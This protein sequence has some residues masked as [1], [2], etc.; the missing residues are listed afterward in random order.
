MSQFEGTGSFEASAAISAFR[1]VTLDTSR[2]V[3]AS[4]TAV[5]PL[6]ITQLDADSG[7][8]VAVKFYP[9]SPGTF[10]VSVT[11]V[12]ITTGDV[13]F[14]GANGQATRTGSAIT[15]GRALEGATTNGAII[16]VAALTR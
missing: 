4:A 10:R 8:F 6:G 14:C 16:E 2:K 7:D 11:G 5:I 3:A 12:P 1:G 9:N 13:L 15:L